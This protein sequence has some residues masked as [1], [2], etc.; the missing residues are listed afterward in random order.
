MLHKLRFFLSS[1]CHLFHN[2]T[3]FGSCNI[4]ILPTE[5]AKI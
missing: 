3:L 2:A 4:R 1:K 5:Y